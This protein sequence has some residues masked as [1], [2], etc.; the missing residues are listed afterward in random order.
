M[1]HYLHTCISWRSH[2]HEYLVHY[3]AR[4]VNEV[5]RV[6]F[7][8]GGDSMIVHE[9]LKYPSLELVV[10]LELD[11]TVVRKSF[12]NMGTQPHFDDE[13]VQWWFGDATTSLLLL[14]TEYHGTFDLVL[15]DLAQEIIEM[16]NVTEGLDINDAAMLLVK[17]DGVLVRNEDW[18]FGTSKSFAKHMV[19]LYFVDVPMT[20]HQGLTMA[21]NGVDFLTRNR[22]DHSID[23]VYLKSEDEMDNRFHRW[24]NY[25]K[26]TNVACK[27]VV[28]LAEDR[29]SALGILMVIEAEDVA[30]SI[31]L[32]S[33][34]HVSRTVSQAFQTVGLSE[35]SV[36]LTSRDE[37]YQLLFILK[38]GYVVAQFW[39]NY[40]HCAFDVMLWRSTE[41]LDLIKSCLV[42][43]V[44]S[45]SVS[46]YRIV[47]SGMFSADKDIEKSKVG[48]RTTVHTAFSHQETEEHS[49][50]TGN[51]AINTPE[52]S[53][54][55]AI[56]KESSSLIEGQSI[57]VLCGD[58]SSLCNS[59][60]L[61]EKENVEPTPVWAWPSLLRDPSQ[62][63]MK[64][65]A[66]DTL[67]HLLESV[68]ATK[69]YNGIVI[70]P[71]ASH[72]M[73]QVLHKMLSNTKSRR[74]LLAERH[75]VFTLS[76]DPSDS[77]WRRALLDRFRTDFAKYDPSYRAEILFTDTGLELGVFSSGDDGFF[78]GLVNVVENIESKTDLTADVR[79][80]KNGINNYVADFVPSKVASHDDYDNSLALNQW[81]SQR[82]LGEQSVIQYE[83]AEDLTTILLEQALNE[84]LSEMS[85]G[86][87]GI[88]VE[89]YNTGGA[90]SVIVGDWTSGSV[91]VTWDGKRQV[92]VNLISSSDPR[93]FERLLMSAAQLRVTSRNEMPR[94]TGRV[95]NFPSDMEDKTP[96]WSLYV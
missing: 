48:P 92:N 3:A 30:I 77:L 47:V 39:P 68:E 87:K 31:D 54:L 18:N 69:K 36:R 29:R 55:D 66:K 83:A 25:R 71:K 37:G 58:P 7:M 10:G 82:V 80:I 45:K 90:G 23:T 8:G 13:R 73:G 79:S 70:D 5:K 88:D 26:S 62:K 49:S 61:L 86:N 94:G 12:K 1:D 95:V 4:Y 63:I 60:K 59:L 14:P 2:Y 32:S 53:V 76:T 84:T 33:A 75:V 67:A 51:D 42:E 44:G 35:T 21:S 52:Q 11:Q 91:V 34:I 46:S 9:V 24:Y 16:L 78:S 38:E 41:K 57:L 56:L 81:N 22:K 64:D 28:A 85:D 65:F 50:T 19:D 72:V 96:R 93:R 74:E 89:A 27:E 40:S 43:A 6:L 17:P 20:C 15:I